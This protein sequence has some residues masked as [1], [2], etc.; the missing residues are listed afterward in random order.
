MST[1][2]AGTQEP[3]AENPR[4]A[5]PGATLRRRA[6][7]IWGLIT[8]PLFILGVTFLAA[9]LGRTYLVRRA[10]RLRERAE[11]ERLDDQP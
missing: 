8:E 5:A 6:G 10:K 3:H 9:I 11:Q 7:C 1:E 2:P 4:E